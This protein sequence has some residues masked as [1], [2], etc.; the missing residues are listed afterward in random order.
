MGLCLTIRPGERIQ[1]GETTITFVKRRSC[2]QVIL[3]FV[4]PRDVQIDRL[5]KEEESY[6]P[7]IKRK[8]RRT[9]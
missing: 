2:N 9:A 5:G 8:K 3:D 1:I 6:P 7:V 4:G